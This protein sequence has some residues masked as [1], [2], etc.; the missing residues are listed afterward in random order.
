MADIIVTDV[1]PRVQYTAGGGS[2]T[3]FSYAFPIFDDTDLNVYLTPVGDDPNDTTQLL[4]YNVDYTVTNSTPP[5]VGGTITLTVGATAGDVITIVRNQP[6]NRLNNYVDGGLFQA[7]DV[8]TDFDR[9]VFMAQQNKMYDQVLGLHYNVCAQPVAIEDTVL[10]VL[11]ANEIWIK[12]NAGTAITTYDFSGGGGGVVNSV[13]GTTNRITAS[14]TT[15][16][17]IVDISASYV[18][19]ASITTLG[20]ITTGTWNGSVVGSAYGGTG[21]STYTLGDIIYCSAANVLSK[22]AGNTTVAKQYLSQT[23]DGVN[24]AAPVWATIDGGDITGAALTKVDD[25]NVTLTLG[26]TPATALLRAASLTL[27]WTGQLAVSRGGTGTGTA[28][29]QGSVI[30]AGAAGVYSQD[31]ASFFWDDTNNRL[32]IGTASPGFD[33]HVSRSAS[34]SAVAARVQNTEATNPASDA[35]MW[36]RTA[37]GGGNPHFVVQVDAAQAYAFGIDQADSSKFKLSRSTALATDTVLT[38]TSAGAATFA[39]SLAADSLSL[40]TPLPVASGGTGLSSASNSAALLS[41]NGGVPVWS[42]SLTNGQLIIGSTGATPVAASL[43]A[44]SGVTIT[45]GAGSITISATGSGGTVTSVSGTANRITSTG[46]TTP[47]ID[48]DA[49][50]VGQS[51]ITTLGT[52]GTGVW[53]GTVV[54]LAYGGTAANLTASTGGIVY[55]GASAL[56]ILAGTATARQMLQSGSSAAPAWSTTTWPATTTANQILY[57]SAASVIGEITTANSAVLVTNSSG[58][59]AFSGTMTNGQLIIGS[60]G[61]TPAAATL[62]AGTGITITNAANSITIAASSGSGAWTKISSSTA[63][64]SA[65]IDFTSLTNAY[66]MYMVVIDR[67]LPAT[68]AVAFQMRASTNN[69]SSYYSTNEYSYANMIAWAADGSYISRGGTGAA[70]CLMTGND[71]NY[72][73]G[74]ATN[75]G[76]TGTFFL[77]NPSGTS[78]GRT[79]GSFSYTEP[80]GALRE[81]SHAGRID[82]AADIDAIRFMFSSGNIASGTFT[83]YG[84]TA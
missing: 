73:V 21:F 13:T 1:T 80:G 62:T 71:A 35:H 20:T 82:Q 59:P 24:S 32:G 51:S 54:G 55:S 81:C 74:N 36:L 41:T 44:G 75:E 14:P 64:S 70:A 30:F 77:Y 34:G 66:M 83:L 40:T 28:F 4:T 9:T 52:I 23:G 57:S 3:V 15:G 48:I 46:G 68:D 72:Y 63:S 69:G 25:T 7:T 2:P 43:T 84:L 61:G 60:T 37:T 39:G 29:T 50:Y 11:G 8:N 5:T 65:T 19:Q 78:Y 16:H 33:L 76:I 49:N 10:P 6:D 31:N 12:D 56:A 79:T 42:S 47:V 18:G 17:V 26:G 38:I 22:L 27:G 67:A 45:P 58:V 53:Q